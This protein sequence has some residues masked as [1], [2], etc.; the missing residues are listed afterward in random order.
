M[1]RASCLLHARTAWC[2]SCFV[3]LPLFHLGTR[4]VLDPWTIQ[5]VFPFKIL[6]VP[7]GMDL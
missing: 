5:S 2:F 3:C 4:F 6:L 7:F 1:P